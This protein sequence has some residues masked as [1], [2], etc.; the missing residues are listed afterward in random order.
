MDTTE[1]TVLD[2]IDDITV[3]GRKFHEPANEY[4]ALLCLR[5]GLEFL[6][7]GAAR[8]GQVARAGLGIPEGVDFKYTSFGNTPELA[9]VRQTLLTCSFQWYA[10]SAC[11]YVWLVGAIAHR[12]DDTRPKPR[13]YALRVIPEVQAFRDKVAAHYSWGTQNSRDNDAER[14]ASILP[15]LKFDGHVF[16]VAEFELTLTRQG[17]PISSEKLQPWSICEVHERLRARY[18]PAPAPTPGEPVK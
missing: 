1:N 9:G 8:S 4:W 7:R 17:K 13:E 14:L 10:V 11:Q 3:P 16:S 2:Y 6:Y 18:W 15:P 12:L 5:D